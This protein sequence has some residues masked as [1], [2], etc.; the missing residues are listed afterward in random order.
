M[1]SRERR[2]IIE[3]MRTRVL[4][5]LGIAAAAG[6]AAGQRGRPVLHEDLPAPTGD[7]PQP[8]IGAA[9][10]GGN[11]TAIP[12]GDK[13]LPMPSLEGGPGRSDRSE[14]V[15]GRGGF[16]A[17]RDTSMRPDE[18]TGADSTLHYVSVF[19][20]DVLPF[21]RMSAF[22][23]VRDDF[24]LHVRDAGT[25]APVPIGGTTDPRTRDRFWGDVLVQL[26]PGIDV[27]LPSVAPDMRIL[28]YQT[29]PRLR[30]AFSRDGADNYYVRSDEANASGTYRLVFLADADAGYF[31]PALPKGY[32][33][34]RDVLAH[35]PPEIRRLRAEL[36]PRVLKEAKLTLKKLGLDDPDMALNTAFNQLVS[37]FRAF[38]AGEIRNPSG[39]V[40][41]DLCDSQTGVCRHRAFAFMITANAMGIPTRYLE[42]EAH[43]F[44]E[45]WFPDR[46][47]QRIDLGGAALRMD[48]AGAND[49][50][51][52]RPRSEDP[53]A[54]P[55]EYSKQYT[56]LEGDI[57]G[58]TEQ[59]LGDKRK[60]LDQAPPSG[61][62]GNGGGGSASAAAAA[63]S[64]AD[65]ITPDQSK[66]AIPP[67]PSKRTVT[68]GITT[69]DEDA[70]RGGFLH[71]EGWARANGKPLA[72]HAVNVWLAPAGKPGH[73]NSIYIGT[74][75]TGSDGMF[76]ADLPLRSDLQLQLE[77]YDIVPTSDPDA[78]NNAQVGDQE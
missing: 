2:V 59:Q 52:H 46:R 27:P 42:N 19:N 21:K 16:A 69:H 13:V 66:V 3:R 29:Q 49:K 41:R 4:V 24:T 63:S 9:S 15:L 25:L 5:A 78:Y 45:V 54:K 7:R 74:A 65:H 44:V 67:D 57:R 43:A 10:K 30:L 34:V 20:P 38:Q 70:F 36:P 8:T 55:P 60:P 53:F 64:A 37:W 14:P 33:Y 47:W 61:A 35:A 77:A 39:N 62:I 31:A 56:Q 23:E 76:R 51:L 17:D 1:V 28:S 32:V 50:T 58:L 12:A 48:V 26:R 75:T 22:D 40:Y 72:D 68:L 11:P 73:P 71:V 18:N 6:L